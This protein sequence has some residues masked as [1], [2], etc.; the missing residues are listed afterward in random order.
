MQDTLKALFLLHPVEGMM[1]V[2]F[3]LL[4]CY[5]YEA[6]SESVNL[7]LKYAPVPFIFSYLLG[8]W[9]R[10]RDSVYFRMVYW[11]SPIVIFLLWLGI[12]AK[13]VEDGM[14]CSVSFLLIH[15]IYLASHREWDD[16]AFMRS[17]LRYAGSWLAAL[18]C[19]GITLLLL[20]SIYYSFHAI[21]EIRP[22][23]EGRFINYSISF[24]FAFVM[25][26][27]FIYFHK[28]GEE[29]TAFGKERLPDVLI[30]WILT[31]ALLIYAAILSLYFLKVVFLWSLPK[32]AV[33]YIAISFTAALFFLQGCQSFVTQ[34]RYDW[35]YEKS[36]WIDLPVLAMF[37]VGTGYRIWQYGLTVQ[38]VY[39]LVVGVVLTC[40][41]LLFL[42]RRNGR[43]LPAACVAI[44]LTAG[45]TYIPGISASDL[46]RYSQQARGNDPNSKKKQIPTEL[47]QIRNSYSLDL[48]GFSTVQPVSNYEAKGMMHL[49]YSLDSIS[50]YNK[51]NKLLFKQHADTFIINQIRKAG[52]SPTDSI[53]EA[54]YPQLLQVDLGDALLLLEEMGIR[55]DSTYHISYI[56]S[57]CYLKRK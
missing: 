17:T 53:T 19:A 30:N 34:R 35:F 24:S 54:C 6:E 7:L 29:G 8:E 3:C 12:S 46:E 57:A 16:T 45:V 40:T 55:R 10:T 42:F 23:S 21:F 9:V 4:A 51:Q 52:F 37:W 47:F 2:F 27:L 38:R 5:A 48:S 20:T 15:L 39:L 32:G 13:T 31:P 22:V 43:Y 25:P 41:A 44:F 49:D 28:R 26:L 50:L 36:G 56:T 18:A 14:M 11:A 33:A 1:A